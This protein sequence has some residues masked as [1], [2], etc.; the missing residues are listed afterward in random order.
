MLCSATSGWEWLVLKWG[1]RAVARG[2]A[3]PLAHPWVSFLVAGLP[4]TRGGTGGRSVPRLGVQSCSLLQ[5]VLWDLLQDSEGAPALEILVQV[6]PTPT[7]LAPGTARILRSRGAAC[8]LRSQ[9]RRL[10]CWQC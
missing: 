8:P 6:L 5:A 3:T 10:C 9:G 2:K 4:R 1:V 7:R